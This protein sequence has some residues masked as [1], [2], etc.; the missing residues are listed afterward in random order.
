MKAVQVFRAKERTK[1]ESRPVNLLLDLCF[2][3]H[4]WPGALRSDREHETADADDGDEL[5][6]KGWLDTLREKVRSSVTQEELGLKPLLLHIKSGQLFFFGDLAGM[7]P[8]HLTVRCFV[9]VLQGAG[10]RV[11]PAHTGEILAVSHV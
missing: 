1:C 11:D 3:P 2:H 9:H 7:P 6:S 4:L 10:P 5:P 8:G